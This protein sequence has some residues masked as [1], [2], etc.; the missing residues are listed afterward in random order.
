MNESGS[1]LKIGRLK[2]EHRILAFILIMGVILRVLNLSD[3][4]MQP[5]EQHTLSQMMSENGEELFLVNPQTER[6]APAYEGAVKFYTLMSGLS[7]LNMRVPS[8]LAGIAAIGF[9]YLLGCKIYSGVA[10]LI[11]AA[12]LGFIWTA[13]E[14]S[15]TAGPEIF[16]MLMVLISGYLFRQIISETTRRTGPELQT[17]LGFTLVLTLLAYTHQFG[18]FLAL[19]FAVFAAGYAAGKKR[20]L[21]P[22]LLSLTLLMVMCAPLTLMLSELTHIGNSPGAL[23][24]GLF[25]SGTSVSGV[26]KSWVFIL[27]ALGATIFSTRMLLSSKSES[28]KSQYSVDL[29][30]G[31]WILIVFLSGVIASLFDV[32][33]S[34]SEVLMAIFP[35][36]ILLWSGLVRM[37]S[38]NPPSLLRIGIG[39][40]FLLMLHS[41]WN[42]YQF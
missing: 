9:I 32:P 26:L 40:S 3:Y 37:I 22:A 23:L 6:Y 39:V 41:L 16:L 12:I 8:I 35:A 17:W 7:L 5:A 10:G 1:L 42:M 13:A 15:R 14:A 11:A 20:A 34:G 18:V 24:S 38:E 31:A 19:M 2:P 36:V 30:L 21:V 25:L 27:T 4:D 28:A 29:F 33:L